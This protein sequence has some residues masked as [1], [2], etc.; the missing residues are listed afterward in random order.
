M[1][2]E[3]T[4]TVFYNTEKHY[5]KINIRG[6][7][8]QGISFWSWYLKQFTIVMYAVIYGFSALKNQ[9]K[10]KTVPGV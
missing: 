3:G 9:H 2:R 4:T 5:M 8:T 7:D 1:D 6:L 10:Q